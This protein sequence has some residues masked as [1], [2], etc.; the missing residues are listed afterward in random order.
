MGQIRRYY[1]VYVGQVQGVGFRWTVSQLARQYNITG[2]VR[3]LYNGNV[4]VEAQGEDVYAFLQDTLEDHGWIRIEDWSC[5]AI[6][7]VPGEKSFK[8]LY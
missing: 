5:K 1:I 6:P 2:Y 8:V 4:E 3:N 7:V